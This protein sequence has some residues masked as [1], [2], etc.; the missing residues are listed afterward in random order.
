MI[1]THPFPKTPPSIRD[2]LFQQGAG[3]INSRTYPS[4]TRE[5]I[6]TAI[7]SFRSLGQ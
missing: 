4:R 6:S 5:G 3:Q 2:I 7:N 1:T